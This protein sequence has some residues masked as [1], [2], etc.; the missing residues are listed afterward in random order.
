MNTFI[1]IYLFGIVQLT[2]NKLR[3]CTHT[4]AHTHKHTR[5]YSDHIH[6][7]THRH[8]HTLTTAHWTNIYTHTNTRADIKGIR[9]QYKASKFVKVEEKAGVRDEVVSLPCLLSPYVCVLQCFALCCSVLQ[10]VAVCCSVL[11]CVAVRCSV[12]QCADTPYVCI[13]IFL[14][15]PVSFSPHQTPL[16][17]RRVS[18]PPTSINPGSR[19]ISFLVLIQNGFVRDNGTNETKEGHRG[20]KP[21]LQEA[22]RAALSLP[23]LL[24]QGDK[25]EGVVS[26]PQV[27]QRYKGGRG[28]C[29]LSQGVVSL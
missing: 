9:V 4:R 27:R 19:K 10:C 17:I 11:Q 24:S 16:R 22:A 2:F 3:S 6:K 14:H 25:R 18:N 23:C 29:L 5:T 20:R 7:H 8:R 28:S 26:L 1:K 13:H 21:R 15:P 12:L